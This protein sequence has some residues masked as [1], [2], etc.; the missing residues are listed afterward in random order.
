M[1]WNQHR[2]TQRK[3]H[4][5][6]IRDK[7]GEGVGTEMPKENCQSS[8]HA[9]FLYFIAYFPLTLLLLLFLWPSLCFF[10]FFW[11]IANKTKRKAN[12]LSLHR[13]RG[14]REVGRK[15]GRANTFVCKYEKFKAHTLSVLKHALI[16]T[17]THAHT[18]T[19]TCEH[20]HTR[21]HTFLYAHMSATW[22]CFQFK[23]H[24]LLLPLLLR[25]GYSYFHTRWSSHFNPHAYKV[26]NANYTRPYTVLYGN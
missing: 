17:H 1:K 4:K 5:E 16:Q 15:R 19:H 18:H 21:T 24:F 7:E 26:L 8:R 22:C 25:R 13:E 6:G 10:L 23:L 9:E 2:Q 12:I 3:R 11:F 14:G 20:S